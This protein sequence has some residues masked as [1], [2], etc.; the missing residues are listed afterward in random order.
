MNSKWLIKMTIYLWGTFLLIFSTNLLAA[1]IEVSQPTYLTS[2]DRYDRNPSIIYDG[3]NYWLF[4]TKAD[5]PGL[6]VRGQGGYNPDADK[7]VVYF[8]KATS[9]TGLAS[10]AETELTLSR[11]NRPPSFDQR[12]VTAVYDGSGIWVIA[13]SGQSGTDRGMY[14]YKYSS[15]GIWTGPTILISDTGVPRRGGHINAVYGS[16]TI[17]IVWECS[18]GTSDFRAYS[19]ATST[20]HTMVD[21]S[22]DKMPKITLM[23]TTLYVVSIEDGTSDI[24]VY[25]ATAD[26]TPSFTHHS[27]AIPGA[28]LPSLYDPCIF[29][30]GNNLYVFAAPYVPANE[31]KYLV[32]TRYSSGSWATQ[33]RVTYGGYGSTYWWEYWPIGYYDGMNLYVFYTTESS[34]PVYGDGEV[35]YL[36]MDWNLSNDHYCYIPNAINQATSGDVINVAEG[37][38]YETQLR[39]TKSLTLSGSGASSTIIDAQQNQPP[40]E[41]VVRVTSGTGGPVLIQGFTIRNPGLDLS[42]GYRIVLAAY[43][44]DAPV[45]VQNCR[46][47]GISGLETYGFYVFQNHGTNAKVTI[48]SS[49]FET[50]WAGVLGEMTK[51]AVEVSNN[52]FHDLFPLI[53]GSDTYTPYAVQFYDESGTHNDQLLEISGNNMHDYAGRGIQ[54]YA[55]VGAKYTNVEITNNVIT[56]VGSSAGVQ[57]GIRFFNAAGDTDNGVYNALISANTITG[58]GGAQSKGIWLIGP[59]NN[60][61]VQ[62]N[63]IGNTG[64]GVATTSGS[65]EFAS[66]L[67]VQNNS[68]TGNTIAVSNGSTDSTNIIDASGNWFGVNTPAGVAMEV[69]SNVDYTP[70]LNDSTDTNPGTLGFQGSFSYLHVDDNSP[71][72]GT[73]GRIQEGVNLVTGSTLNVAAG[74]YVEDITIGKSLTLIGAGTAKGL[75]LVKPATDQAYVPP[76]TNSGVTVM[77][78]TANNVTIKDLKVDGTMTAGDPGQRTNMA[79]RGIY[80]LSVANLR[81]EGCE[82]IRCVSGIVGVLSTNLNFHGN[83][84][85]DCGHS[86]NVGGG[87]YLWGSSGNV[88]TL[89]KPNILTNIVDC[90]I[91]YDSSSSGNAMYNQMT[92]CE[93]GMLV[94]E[95][96][97]PTTFDHNNIN[98]TSIYGGIQVV[99]PGAAVTISNNSVLCDYDA[100][101]VF[102]SGTNTVTVTD[103]HFYYTSTKGSDE[104]KHYRIQWMGEEYS[105]KM[106]VESL[107]DKSGESGI[108]LSTESTYGDGPVHATITGNIVAGYDYDVVCHERS[109]DPSQLM[110]VN[111]NGSSATNYFYGYGTYAWYMDNCNDNIDAQYNYWAS[112]TPEDVIWHQVD[113]DSLGLVNF[114]NNQVP[115]V[116]LIPSFQLDKCGDK[117]TLW[118]NMD[119]HVF[120]MEAY[121]CSLSYNNSY[122]TPNTVING[123]DLPAGSFK[124]YYFTANRIIINVGILSGNFD[125]PGRILGIVLTANNQTLPDSTGVKFLASIMRDPNNQNI[126]HTTSDAYIKI[127]CT[128][129]TVRVLSPDSA[130]YYKYFPTLQI[131]FTDNLNLNRGYYRIDNC[132]GAWTEYWSYN[133]NSNDTTISWTVPSVSEGYHKIYFKVTD[134]ASNKNDDTCSYWWSFYYDITSPAPPTDFVARPG[135]QKCKLSWKSPTGD[136]S[137]HKVMVR[138]NPWAVGA[139]PEYDDDFPTPLGFPGNY[140]QGTFVCTTSVESYRDSNNTTAFPRNAYFYGAF[141]YDK[142]G[143][144]SSVAASA[145]DTATNYWLGD[146]AGPG[147]LNNYDGQVYY[148]DLTWFSTTFWKSHG[149][150]FYQNQFDIG[151]TYNGS[152]KGIPMTDNII[153]FE[154]LS[155]FSINFDAVFPNMKIAPIFAEEEITGPLGLQLLVPATNYPQVGAAFKVRVLLRNNP[156]VVKSIHF[157][158]PYNA[159]QLEFVRV[160]KSKLLQGTTWPVFFNGRDIDHNID[161]NLALLGGEATIGGSGEI[162]IITFKLL[163]S[164]NLSLAF[165]LIDFRDN[166]NHKLLG[167]GKILEQE[168]SSELPSVYGLSQNYPNTFNPSTQIAYQLP[169]AGHVS[170]KIYNIKGELVC[171]LVNQYKE[172]G[173]HTV[174]WDGKNE[175][176]EEVASGVYFYRMVSNDFKATKKMIMLK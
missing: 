142:A 140:T 82:V 73:T 114:A 112:T 35:A 2:N 95:N 51:A 48:T 44:T 28:G 6:A 31:Q 128:N 163:Q 20:L 169:Q 134:D 173:H 55:D 170:L 86:F 101:L 159:S 171:T 25:S 175:N 174:I 148:E 45:T 85:D 145:E 121:Y 11:T 72:T 54:F 57:A 69:S 58:A 79:K 102:N 123:P 168:L 43:F 36:K 110:D 63:F 147:G 136:P 154:D 41:G 13:S 97:N 14:Y 17:Y 143:N 71:Q 96:N 129:P 9:I 167:D 152:A 7:Y 87:I 144:F 156:D 131:R 19:I 139:Y 89:A 46:L 5:Q 151:P 150:P 26:T 172:A 111:A 29:N 47:I 30:D 39:I 92:N 130:G 23:G 12:V 118:I 67:V 8:K 66:G 53:E 94:N 70:W 56:S 78:V 62:N 157:T 116:S 155:I 98:G 108:Y 88:G 77:T 105:A 125:G 16:G 91:M 119:G 158:L 10:A 75:T 109:G 3:S 124:S 37:I 135:H 81:V 162:A 126:P 166:Q 68:L 24:E 103:N 15:E 50:L 93:L 160:E 60:V 4:Y 113:N 120:D 122:I 161:V 80:G 21:I 22:S 146:V 42:Y 104:Q 165:N 1:T 84:L 153:N 59:N 176:G 34:S 138:R 49:E 127:D 74:T 27:T 149:Q 106:A 76:P 52:D 65:A 99:H 164:G 40:D 100:L 107:N 61:T 90:G 137:F 33:H 32:Q 115:Q 117:D 133:S 83:T 141:S 18:D 64:T 132:T 38:Y